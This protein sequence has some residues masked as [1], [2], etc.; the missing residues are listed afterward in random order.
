MNGEALLTLSA[1]SK[2]FGGLKAV[3]GLDLAVPARQVCGLIG[4]NGAGKTTVFNL[5]TGVYRPNRGSIRLGSID[6]TGARPE[7]I[8]SRGVARTFQTIRLFPNL[9]TWEH[10]RVAQNC[11]AP[12]FIGLCSR[13]GRAAEAKLRQEAEEI[14]SLLELWD[15]RHHRAVTLPYGRQRKVEMARALATKPKL[16][17]L[18][19]PAA[20]MNAT[21]TEELARIICQ[22][23]EMGVAVLVIEHDMN[24]ITGICEHLIVLNFG[25]RLAAGRC[26]EVMRDAKVLEAY[27]GK[28]D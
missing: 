13:S 1:V 5:I 8:T 24:F 7:A 21:E 14:L 20:G 9:T 25:R 27:I 26:A 28:E 6:I 2:S 23:K 18:D 17:L 12:S 22:I 15:L 11:R 16:L 3:D 10:V 19:E 4:P